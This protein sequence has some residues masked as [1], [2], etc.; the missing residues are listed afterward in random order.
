MGVRRKARETALKVLYQ[1]DMTGQKAD[2]AFD[3]YCRYF[4]P[5][6][7][8]VDFARKLCLGVS[9]NRPPI[10]AVLEASSENW[11]LERMA[12]VDRNI[13]RIAI[14]EMRYLADIPTRVTFNEAIELGKRYGAD[15]SGSFINGILDRIAREGTGEGD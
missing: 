2:R 6:E 9:E 7:E 5:D 10:D 13:L 1:I 15:E 14:F 12:P 11:S 4:A 8:T 3:L